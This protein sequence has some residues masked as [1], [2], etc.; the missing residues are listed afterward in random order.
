MFYD[1]HI[2]MSGTLL[3]HGHEVGAYNSVYELNVG[4]SFTILNNLE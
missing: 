1:V 4:I 2:S 3:F